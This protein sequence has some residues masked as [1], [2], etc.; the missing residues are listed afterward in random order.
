MT[1]YRPTGFFFL[2]LVIKNLIIINGIIFFASYIIKELFDYDLAEF[3]SLHHWSSD[4]FQI[5]QVITHMFM[6]ED[7]EHVLFNMVGL[8]IFGAALEKLWNGKRFL[9]YYLLTGIG[10]A[11]F[12]MAVVT[13]QIADLETRVAAFS[14]DPTP[15]KYDKIMRSELGNHNKIVEYLDEISSRWYE[16]IDAGVSE[17]YF[18]QR[19]ENELAD[20]V[21]RKRNGSTKGASG[22][23]YGIL[24]GFGMMFPNLIMFLIPIK[25]KYFVMIYGAIALLS[26]LKD[27]PDDNVA[28]FA[29]LGGMVVG[30]IILKYWK[31]K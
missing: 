31:P 12:H 5:Y 2:P 25:A 13:F 17:S 26:G 14:L 24:L 7:F 22:A 23:V 6:H 1:Q 27:N 30:F 9:N 4:D 15:A 19:S 16:V 8:W 3:L 29:H 28:H 11:V 18:I 10:A 21:L 20:L